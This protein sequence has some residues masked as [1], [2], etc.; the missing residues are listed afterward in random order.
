MKVYSFGNIGISETLLQ[1]EMCFVTVFLRLHVQH[2][3]ELSGCFDTG[4]N[5]M[6]N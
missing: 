5:S 3:H 2:G 6:Q 4:N 1:D